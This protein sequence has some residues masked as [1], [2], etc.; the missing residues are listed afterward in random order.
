MPI[1]YQFDTLACICDDNSMKDI[2]LLS[3]VVKMPLMMLPVQ[4]PII[5]LSSANVMIS[6][7]SNLSDE[8]IVKQNNI[9]DIVGPNLF[10]CSGI[11]KVQ[12]FFPNSKTWAPT[13]I[14]KYKPNL[15]VN[16]ILDDN[17]WP[18]Q[19][20]LALITLKGAPRI[21]EFLFFHKKSK[22]LIVTDICF[23]L[24]EARGLGAWLI[25][26]IFGTYRRLAMSKLYLKGIIDK[27]AFEKS[28]SQI[29]LYDFENIIINH[30]QNITTNAREK[31]LLALKERNLNLR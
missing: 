15:K 2:T 28:L 9:T 14:E 24:T 27:P 4:T 30:G 7:G 25:L 21:N 6:P 31:L 5:H 20:E 12:K 8:Q 19:S 10:H 29:F 16:N 18:Y 11:S 26:N 22:T 13:G 23:N 1:F 17:S 3:S